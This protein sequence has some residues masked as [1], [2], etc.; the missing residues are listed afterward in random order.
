MLKT[1]G[2]N[3]SMDLTQIR[4]LSAFKTKQKTQTHS[5]STIY[6]LSKKC[7][8][9]HFGFLCGQGLFLMIFLDRLHIIVTTFGFCTKVSFT[10]CRKRLP[11]GALAAELTLWFSPQETG[12]PFKLS[13]L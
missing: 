1:L 12:E 13:Q 5:H 2:K 3:K 8:Q 6:G 11:D 4:M 10:F 7:F 9:L